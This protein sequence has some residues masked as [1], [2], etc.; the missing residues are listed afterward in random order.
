MKIQP[1]RCKST[2]LSAV[3]ANTVAAAHVPVLRF[4]EFEQ[5][6]TIQFSRSEAAIG[7][8]VRDAGI[9]DTRFSKADL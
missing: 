9:K 6:Q 8:S 4:T 1:K 7:A 2:Q 3:L 5:C